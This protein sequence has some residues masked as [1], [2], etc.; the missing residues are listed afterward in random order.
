[1]HMIVVELP[2]SFSVDGCK[3]GHLDDLSGSE[4]REDE[5][6][7]VPFLKNQLDETAVAHNMQPCIR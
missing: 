3:V 4:D 2:I 7:D 5:M 1:M 6:C